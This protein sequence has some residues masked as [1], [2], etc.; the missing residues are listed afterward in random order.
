MMNRRQSTPKAI[1]AVLALGLCAF[2]ASAANLFIAM[3]PEPSAATPRWELRF[4]V[5][6]PLRL[7]KVD[8][9][10][11]W[12]MTYVVQNRTNEDQIFVPNA[13]LAT[14]YGHILKDGEVTYELTKKIIALIGSPFLKS[15]NEIIGSLK[16]GKEYAEE[17]L[18]VWKAGDLDEVRDVRVFVGGLSSDTQVVTNPVTGEE[19]VVRKH[20]AF[21]FDCPGDPTAHPDMA[22]QLRRTHWIMR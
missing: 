7:V 17:G 22:V 4:E 19:E 20:L 11:Y 3:P 16:Q 15:K 1:A 10:Y 12:I 8:K 6:Q 2:P 14:D 18:L 5:E 13:I 9:E 21:E